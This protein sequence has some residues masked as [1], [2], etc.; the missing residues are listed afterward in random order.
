MLLACIWLDAYMLITYPL[1]L[2]G[3]LPKKPG[4]SDD[5]YQRVLVG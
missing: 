3:A 1:R 2:V 5:V 4:W